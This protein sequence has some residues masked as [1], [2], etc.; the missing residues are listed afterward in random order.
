[1]SHAPG[2]RRR[3]LLLVPY[4]VRRLRHD[5]FAYDARLGQLTA[6][7]NGYDGVTA[8]AFNQAFPA[9]RYL[10]LTEVR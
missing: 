6:T 1:M 7:H 4:V 3:R 9:V 5:V 8:I 2:E 10:G